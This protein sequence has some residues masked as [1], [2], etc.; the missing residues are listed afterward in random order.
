MAIVINKSRPVKSS[1]PLRHVE[2]ATSTVDI[3]LSTTNTD[4][5]AL[6]KWN[7]AH[8]ATDGRGVPDTGIDFDSGGN[9]IPAN[10]VTY[11]GDPVE[12][13]GE[14]VTYTP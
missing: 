14:Y 3:H 4:K 5:L 7:Q 13:D 11:N 9:E 12:H 1:N 8:S 2:Y 10:T 6:F